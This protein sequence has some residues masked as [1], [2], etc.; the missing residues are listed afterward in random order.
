MGIPANLHAVPG[1]LSVLPDGPVIGPTPEPDD[2]GF[3]VTPGRS[4]GYRFEK[5]VEDVIGVDLSC[6]LLFPLQPHI[7][8]PPGLEFPLV[9]LGGGTVTLSM[10]ELLFFFVGPELQGRVRIVLNV[11][12]QTM[13]FNNEFVVSQRAIRLRVHWHTHGQAQ[14]WHEGVLRAYEPGFAVGRSFGIDRLAVGGPEGAVAAPNPQ[15]LVRRVYLKLLRRDDARHEIDWHV[16]IDVGHFPQTHCAEHVRL[17]H[18][19][20]LSRI[21]KFMEGIVS[22]FTTSWR[23]GQ[24]P[25]P[26]SPE[27]V[28]AHE[29]AVRAAEAF[30]AFLATREADTAATFLRRIGEFLDV[31]A[32]AAPTGYAELLAELSEHAE[33]LDPACRTMLEPVYAANAATLEPLTRLLRAT[34][35]RAKTALPGDPSA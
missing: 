22:E 32:S 7:F 25:G 10:S 13:Q 1:V 28:T 29:A 2:R 23:E 11:D 16:P 24:V 15:F 27:S 6:D 8:Q 35:E 12:G 20:L 26:F 9:S 33:T 18:E 5:R 34:W 14:V 21:R 17:L 19:Q 3:V 30:V 4:L 31:L